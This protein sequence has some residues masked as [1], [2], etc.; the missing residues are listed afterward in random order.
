MHSAVSLLTAY[1]TLSSQSARSSFYHH[2]TSPSSSKGTFHVGR[3]QALHPSPRR[4]C[5][6]GRA[7]VWPECSD[8]MRL[9]QKSR[10]SHRPGV[11]Q[12]EVVSLLKHLRIDRIGMRHLSIPAGRFS[13]D[14]FVVCPSETDDRTDLNSGMLINDIFWRMITCIPSTSPPDEIPVLQVFFLSKPPP[15]CYFKTVR[16]RSPV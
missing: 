2:T 8:S 5:R 14:H 1:S 6:T 13:I 15:G 16:C 12:S 10:E 4:R 7:I 9:V 3:H 11:L